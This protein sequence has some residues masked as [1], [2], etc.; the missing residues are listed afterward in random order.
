MKRM[1]VVC[2]L[3]YILQSSFL[4]AQEEPKDEEILPP[5]RSAAAKIGGA[6][7]F[8]PSW[9]FIDI[10]PINQV[11][12]NAQAAPFD[13]G[14]LMMYGG[15]GYA[16][17][18]FVPNLR[19]GGMGAGGTM[20]SR[21]LSGNI[22]RDIELSAAFGGVTLDYVIPV[23]PRFDLTLGMLFG[24]GGMDLKITRDDGQAKAWDDLWNNY[25]NNFSP[26]QDYT[27]KLSNS[28]FVYQPS[29]NVEF[30]LLRWIG[31]RAGVSYM[32]ISGS[33]W[34]LDDRYDVFGVPS[35]ISGKG[36]MIN[37]GIFL[38]TFVY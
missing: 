13:N 28:F 33:D 37:T 10:G 26:T 29:V 9:L 5:K 11:L 31:L 3:M 38:G 24:K 12:N 8:T 2:V 18:L 17:V 25:G 21:S 1:F 35:T 30:S 14:R 19:I 7:G 15:Q 27:R 16:Y 20:T 4:I 32:A 36:W 6:V 22:R 23:A 34:T